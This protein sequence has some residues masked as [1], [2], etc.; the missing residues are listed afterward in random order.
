MLRRLT[1]RHKCHAVQ[2]LTG[3]STFLGT[4]YGLPHRDGLASSLYLCH[5]TFL[6]NSSQ[7]QHQCVRYLLLRNLNLD[8]RAMMRLSNA[9]EWGEFGGAE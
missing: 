8:G 5:T 4:L 6:M 1:E 2:L 9:R 3:T 7:H